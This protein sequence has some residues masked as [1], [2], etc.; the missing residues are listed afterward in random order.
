MAT[1]E[2]A[3]VQEFLDRHGKVRRYFRRAGSG[4]GNQRFFE[5][6]LALRGRVSSKSS[7]PQTSD[8][9]GYISTPSGRQAKV[10]P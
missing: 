2:L 9:F 1:I 7:C 8:S 3:Y 4:E 10:V 6:A 5:Y